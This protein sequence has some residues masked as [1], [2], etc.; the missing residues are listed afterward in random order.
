MSIYQDIILDHY[1]SP[2]NFG[3][4]PSP[5]NSV[6]VYNSL[7]GDKLHFEIREQ[8]GVVSEIGFSGEGC[9]ISQATASLLSEYA[10]GKNSNTLRSL[11]KQFILEMI[12]VPLSPNRIKCALLSW[13]ALIKVVSHGPK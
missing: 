12:G 6:D 4:L 10:K 5:T 9:A 13:E 7:C 2:R 3:K 1:R 8:G 11:D